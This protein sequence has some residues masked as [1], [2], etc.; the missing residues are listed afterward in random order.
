MYSKSW[1]FSKTIFWGHIQNFAGLLLVVLP[2]VTAVNFP[3]L[4]QWVFGAALVFSG[5]LTYWLRSVTDK[6][7]R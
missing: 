2:Y 4:P 7:I 5:V 1:L 3:D 6:P